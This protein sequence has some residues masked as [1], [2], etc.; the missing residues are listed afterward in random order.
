MMPPPRGLMLLRRA[1]SMRLG[2]TAIMLGA[3]SAARAMGH[4][5]A[6]ASADD[7]TLREHRYPQVLPR[8]LTFPADFGAHP[9]FRTEWWYM[10][11]WLGEGPAAMGFQITF[12]RSRTRHPGGNPS[13]F[14]P[15][16]LMFAHAALAIPSEGRLRVSDRAAR[17]GVAEVEFSTTD[18]HLQMEDWRLQRSGRVGSDVYAVDVAGS[19]F[20]LRLTAA[21]HAGPIPRGRDGVSAKGP[22]ARYASYY[23]SRPHLLVNAEV[24]LRQPGRSSA[25]RV[26]R[27]RIA[28]SAWL[29]HEW[30]SSLLMSGA[31]GWDWI[32]IHL[33]DGGSL[34]AF[35]IRDAQSRALWAHWDERRADGSVTA[36][37]AN[38][39]WAPV[40][41]WR[42]PHSLNEYP[43]EM[44]LV[45][46]GRRY[47]LRPLMKDQEVD[48]RASTGGYYWEGAVVLLR[49]GREVGRGY[50]ELTGYGQPLQI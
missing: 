15:T 8:A 14:A 40:V 49:D 32:G 47:L 22:E 20:S 24:V 9:D 17:T 43:V 3:G 33:D 34:M 25:D 16:Q 11:G 18:C 12:F 10:T 1:L 46:G 37:D 5:A 27:R 29:D 35:R 19:D 23:Y 44:S 21:A 28:G 48:A 36:R 38:V 45:H 13:R 50:L 4:V 2:A 41:Q 7:S 42:S 6:A 39:T 30:S 26:S 31:T